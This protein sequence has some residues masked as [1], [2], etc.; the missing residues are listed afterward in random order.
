MYFWPIILTEKILA[1]QVLE[2]PVSITNFPKL[3]ILSILFGI[4]VPKYYSPN[5]L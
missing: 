3:R 5:I 4:E 1:P 2:L